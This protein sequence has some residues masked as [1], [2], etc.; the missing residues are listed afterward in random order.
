MRLDGKVAVVTGASRG[1]G[2]AIAIRLAEE[3]ARVVI[4]HPGEEEAAQE[5]VEAIQDRGGTAIAVAADVADPEAVKRLFQETVARFETVDI[6]VNNAG[7]CPFVSWFDVTVEIWDRIH[8]VNLRGA[9]LCSQAA[10]RIMVDHHHGGRIISLS[11]ISALVGGSFQTAYTP[12]KAGVKSLMQSLAIVL[13][14]YGITCNSILPGTILTDINRDHYRDQAILERD[15]VRVPLGRL[16][17]P[18][19]IAGVAAFLASDDAAYINGAEIL[20]DGGLFVNLQ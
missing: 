5:V 16:G 14:P 19:D 7:I 1:I 4:D 17:K 15:T 18:E 11:S 12:T 20:V 6:L 3:G 9:F 13:G 2:R 10:S 8:H